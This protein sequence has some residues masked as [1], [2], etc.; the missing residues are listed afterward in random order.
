MFTSVKK[1][2]KMKSERKKI[3]LALFAH[4]DHGP[5]HSPRMI[6][7]ESEEEEQQWIPPNTW[8]CGPPPAMNSAHAAL[9]VASLR[10]SSPRPFFFSSPSSELKA[11]LIAVLLAPAGT[12]PPAKAFSSP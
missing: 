6:I 3:F 9:R 2:K 8:L 4:M 11:H 10:F 12:A 5:P 7:S 1:K